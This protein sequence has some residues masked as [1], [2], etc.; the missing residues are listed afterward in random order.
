M[1][2]QRL[3]AAFAHAGWGCTRD[4]FHRMYAELM[5]HDQESMPAARLPRGRVN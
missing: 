5:A 3:S 1:A 4:S 2:Q